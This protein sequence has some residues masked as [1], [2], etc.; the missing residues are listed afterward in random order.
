MTTKPKDSASRLTAR[1]TAA[2][3]LKVPN[4]GTEWL[5]SMIQAARELDAEQFKARL[6]EHAQQVEQGPIRTP[7]VEY[8]AT[9]ATKPKPQGPKDRPAGGAGVKIG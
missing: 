3:Q 7:V 5:D 2:M 8:Q 4:S 1:E 9:T 6:T